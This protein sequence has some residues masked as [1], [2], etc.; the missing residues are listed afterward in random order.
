MAE[1]FREQTDTLTYYD[2]VVSFSVSVRRSFTTQEYTQG[3]L[4]PTEI[5]SIT[6]NS[7]TD[8]CVLYHGE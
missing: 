1:G 4:E 8:S 2:S 5:V 7:R 3:C 6:Q